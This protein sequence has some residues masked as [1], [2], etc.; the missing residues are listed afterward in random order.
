M[1]I[2]S[3]EDCTSNSSSDISKCCSLCPPGQ[4]V[5]KKCTNE[6]DTQCQPCENGKSFSSSKYETNPCKKCRT[7]RDMERE[8]SPC[9][10]TH[11]TVCRCLLDF[12]FAEELKKCQLCDS[13]PKGSGA[14]VACSSYSNSVCKKCE[15]G[16]F[17]DVKSATSA[18][19]PCSVCSP[20]QFTVMECTD[21]QDT[22]CLSKY[23]KP[24]VQ[25]NSHNN[26]V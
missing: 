18:C 25:N 1:E 7:C 23:A 16:T 21:E 26:G 20:S 8:I 4:G 6:T 12:Y 11:D 9:N 10:S 17:S 19:R 15:N 22:M 2:L 5:V 13:C 3:Y 24:S 14:I